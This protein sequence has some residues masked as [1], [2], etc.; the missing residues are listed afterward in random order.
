MK[1]FKKIAVSAVLLLGGASVQ[2]GVVN[3]GGV[4]IDIGTQINTTTIWE[5]QITSL[6]DQFVGVGYITEIL[7]PDGASS[8]WQQGDND[9]QLSF[10][11]SDYSI[12]AFTADVTTTVSVETTT[13]GVFV[14]VILDVETLVTS[15]SLDHRGDTVWTDAM[16]NTAS[17]LFFTGGKVDVYVDSM[18][19]GTVLDPVTSS[20]QV[21]DIAKATDGDEWLNLVGHADPLT[22]YTLGATAGTT[23]LRWIYLHPCPYAV[24]WIC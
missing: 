13:P 11:L 7:G 19:T 10:K 14:D 6:T 5:T 15:S 22:G 24:R 4:D 12:A 9:A 18:S 3:I 16:M 1:N 8:A 23:G 20:G 21:E 2:A 17:N